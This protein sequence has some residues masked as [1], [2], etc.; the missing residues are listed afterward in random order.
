MSKGTGLYLALVLLVLTAGAG[1]AGYSLASRRQAPP[2]HPTGPAANGAALSGALAGAA[3]GEVP[4]ATGVT[5]GRVGPDTAFTYRTTYR[6]CQTSEEMTSPAPPS[7]LGLDEAALRQAYPQWQVVSFRR[8]QVLLGRE[9]DE[10]CPEFRLWRHLQLDNGFVTVF[11]GRRESPRKLVKER[12]PIAADALSP[13]DRSRL[14]T[15][16]DLPGDEAV[17]AFLE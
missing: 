8:Q 4:A 1:A 17:R 3:G 16:V 11:Y 10:L 9:T 6:P 5:A 12:T 15:G 2:S 7:L 13:A 14:L